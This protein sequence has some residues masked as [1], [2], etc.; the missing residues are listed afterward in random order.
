MDEM[1]EGD[2]GPMQGMELQAHC[3]YESCTGAGGDC[4]ISAWHSFSAQVRDDWSWVAVSACLTFRQI[5]STV[6]AHTQS[7]Y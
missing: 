7:L 4:S 3:S 1:R 5:H 2:G 6:A